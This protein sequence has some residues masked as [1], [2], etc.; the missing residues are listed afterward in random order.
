MSPQDLTVLIVEDDDGDAQLIALALEEYG[1]GAIHHVRAT[2]LAQAL[3]HAPGT[4]DAVL[5]D[6]NLPDGQ[7][8][9]CVTA[10][11]SHFTDAAVAVLTG[12]NEAS[13]AA[14]AVRSGAQDY[15]V[16]G[17]LDGKELVSALRRVV[18][19]KREG[20][21]ER[22]RE[23][24]RLQRDFIANVSHEFRTPIAAIKGAAET[25]SAEDLKPSKRPEFVDIISRHAARLERL[26]EDLLLVS[27]L[28]AAQLPPEPRPLDLRPAVESCLT[29]LGPL[30]DK[31]GVK[32][33]CEIAPSLR[34]RADPD[35]LERVLLSLCGNAVEYNKKG[36]SA[37]VSAARQEGSVVVEVRD[38]GMG[39]PKEELPALFDRFHR[40]NAARGRKSSGTGL[41]LMIVKKLVSAHG[42]RVWAESR[43]GR[44][45]TFR[46]SLP[47]A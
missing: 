29:E 28:D 23:R 44:G 41:G 36:G 46:F 3:R 19:L 27:A 1:R 6:M 18:A 20:E 35:Q 10:V 5:V 45:S 34:V 7:G 12:R 40:S 22:L 8:L 24:D 30:A 43:E 32:L 47:P 31:R 42:G 39:I 38:T 14:A 33:A 9:E 2:T 11:A 15:F 26:V 21:L 13:L 4:C 25:L 16:K 17:D 37:V